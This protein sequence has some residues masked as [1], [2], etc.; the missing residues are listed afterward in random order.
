MT[1]N[2]SGPWIAN[3]YH[4]DVIEIMQDSNG[5]GATPIATVCAP[6]AC[7][8][9]LKNAELIRAAPEL[10]EAL[11]DVVQNFKLVHNPEQS[12]AIRKAIKL[13]NQLSK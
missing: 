6:D 2:T 8:Y 1:H 3:D 12:K 5:R 11:R 4:S 13:V 9:G 10:L 7:E